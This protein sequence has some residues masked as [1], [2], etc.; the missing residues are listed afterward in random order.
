MKS[1]RLKRRGLFFFEELKKH[2]MLN[3]VEGGEE[4]EGV[5]L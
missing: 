1:S 3:L 4:V 5:S 2:K